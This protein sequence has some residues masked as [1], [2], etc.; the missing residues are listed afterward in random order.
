MP[1][2]SIVIPTYNRKHL[3]PRSLDSVLA[4]V[5]VDY[6]LII[7][8]DGS[9]DGTIEMIKEYLFDKP[10]F[11]EKIKIYRFH[12]NCGI[13]TALNKGYSVA[14]G[15]Y[16]CQLSSD[17]WWRP[18]K[19]KI[20]VEFLEEPRNKSFGLVYSRY[21]FVDFYDSGNNL[22]SR[23]VKSFYS[24]NKIVM[25]RRL[26]NDCFMNAC[27]FLFRKE[28]YKDIG[29]YSLHPDYEW[30][31][32]LHFNFRSLFSNWDIGFIDIPLAYLSVHN[33][34]ASKQGKCGL[35]NHVLFPEMI[36][37]GKRRNWI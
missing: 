22:G 16:L 8:D 27:T 29:E 13:P 5:F 15:K 33:G 11:K 2:V 12:K 19:L 25:Y 4:Q 17:D 14:T 36:N 37:E 28:F 21:Y 3:L 9:T 34:Q 10:N 20:N 30:N 26:F 23:V 32:D 24:E 1:L 7:V 35:G 18:D 6:E 31:Q